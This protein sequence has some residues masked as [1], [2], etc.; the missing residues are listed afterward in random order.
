MFQIFG[1]KSTFFL[2]LFC[3]KGGTMSQ[4]FLAKRPNETVETFKVYIYIVSIF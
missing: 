3:I 4:T 1:E 2:T